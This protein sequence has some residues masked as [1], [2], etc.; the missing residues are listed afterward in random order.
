[1]LGAADSETDGA[2][3]TVTVTFTDCVADPPG[4]VHVRANAESAVSAPVFAEPEVALAPLQLPDA[5]QLLASVEVHVSVADA[6]WATAAGATSSV[7]VGTAGAGGSCV[8]STVTVWLA[9]PAAPAQVSVYA[10]VD[11]SALV[12]SAPLSALGPLQ[13]PDATQ[14]DALVDAQV[15]LAVEACWTISGVAARASVGATGAGGVVGAVA[16]SE[17]SPPPQ[18]ASSA[19]ATGNVS[20]INCWKA[21]FI[22]KI[23]THSISR[24]KPAMRRAGR[25]EPR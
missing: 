11:A 2:A 22:G 17:E 16:G 12:V 1:V 25:N 15:R 14:L 24:S 18:L 3:G 8:T 19:T 5:E 10:V 4:P 20:R 6:P 23:R 13:P 21:G 7:T 9:E